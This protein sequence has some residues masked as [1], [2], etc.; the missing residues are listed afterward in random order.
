[1]LAGAFFFFG[2][3]A[4]FGVRYQTTH[5]Q[6]L[7]L[8]FE[9]HRVRVTPF[10]GRH[11]LHA[12]DSAL[13]AV[14]GE[15]AVPWLEVH[16]SHIFAKPRVAQGKGVVLGNEEPAGLVFVT[17]RLVA[18]R[19]F[20]ELALARAVREGGHGAEGP[21]ARAVVNGE[22]FLA[23]CKVAEADC[24]DFVGYFIEHPHGGVFAE[25]RPTAST[26]D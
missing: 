16:S 22:H 7:V 15:E 5:N 12:G 6:Q 14:F 9:H 17:G 18:C 4:W 11:T 21:F 25:A 1:M 2:S 10:L 19:H 8:A 20:D 23:H 26:T 3:V 13:S 24:R